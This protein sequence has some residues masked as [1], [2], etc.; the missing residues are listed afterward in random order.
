MDDNK[1][2]DFKIEIKKI[3]LEEKKI[4][5]EREKFAAEKKW[6][7]DKLEIEKKKARWTG[8]S[9]LIPLLIVAITFVAN[10]ILDYQQAKREFKIQAAKIVMDTNHPETIRNKSRALAIL[11][12]EYLSEDFSTTFNPADVSRPSDEARK[13][14]SSLISLVIAVE[15]DE[16]VFRKKR[17]EII[18]FWGK[19]HPGDDTAKTAFAINEFYKKILP[20]HYPLESSGL[21]NLHSSVTGP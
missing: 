14:I 2:P 18:A 11:F 19:L 17:E 3:E 5:L 7:L 8:I 16:N 4:A 15:A 20:D 21:I 12:P 9:I 1:F 6:E 13:E 10:S